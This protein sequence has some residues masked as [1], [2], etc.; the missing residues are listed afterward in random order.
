MLFCSHD[1]NITT[2]IKVSTDPHE[3]RSKGQFSVLIDLSPW[4]HLWLLVTHFS[5]IHFL[6][7]APRTP[8]SLDFPPISIVPPIPLLLP[9]H[10]SEPSVL[11][12]PGS[13][14]GTPFFSIHIHSLGDPIQSHGFTFYLHAHE[15][16]F[17]CLA[18]YMQLPTGNIMSWHFQLKGPPPDI[19]Y[20]HPCSSHG[21]SYL[22]QWSLYS[23]SPCA[24]PLRHTLS[25]FQSFELP[26]NPSANPVDANFKI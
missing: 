21:F 26:I 18:L 12:Y 5:F 14:L 17:I 11:G 2:F 19:R 20:L 13:D 1:S 24:K 10:L 8:E 23:S 6:P 16:T 25:P 7:L 15:F 22:H 9:L 4:Q 3:A